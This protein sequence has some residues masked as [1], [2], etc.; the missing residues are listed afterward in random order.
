MS[1]QQPQ[2]NKK[3]LF[4]G[5]LPWSMRDEDLREI[6]GAFGTLVDVHLV[7]DKFSGRSKGFAFV[8]YETEEEAQAAITEMSG[9]DIDGR[10]LVVNV[11][12]PKTA[13]PPRRDFDRRGGGG[14]GDRGGYGGG[15]NRGGGGYGGGGNRDY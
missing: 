6:F 1:D 3:K 9:K 5:N 7:T 14:G 10:E 11:A 2:E 15:G 13:R 4:I 8:E 12:R